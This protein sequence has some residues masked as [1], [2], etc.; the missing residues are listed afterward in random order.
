MGVSSSS[1]SDSELSELLD[2]VDE[3]TSSGKMRRRALRLY[4]QSVI[5]VVINFFQTLTICIADLSIPSAALPVFAVSEVTK[6]SSEGIGL[7]CF[8]AFKSFYSRYVV[9]MLLPVIIMLAILALFSVKFFIRYPGKAAKQHKER[10]PEVSGSGSSYVDE[11]QEVVSYGSSYEEYETAARSLSLIVGSSSAGDTGDVSVERPEM[12]RTPRSKWVIYGGQV[13]YVVFLALNYF[14]FPITSFVLDVF[15]C[16]EDP[17]SGVSYMVSQPSLACDYLSLW[18][19]L[20]PLAAYVFLPILVLF[21]VMVWLEMYGTNFLINT[22]FGFWLDPYRSSRRYFSILFLMRRFLLAVIVTFLDVESLERHV[23]I[24]G[25]LV[26]S[27]VLDYEVKPF[28]YR[29]TTTVDV[30]AHV[31]LIF[32][33]ATSLLADLL[34]VTDES[35]SFA[36]TVLIVCMILGGLVLIW[37]V[38]IP[39]YTVLVKGHWHDQGARDKYLERVRAA[40]AAWVEGESHPYELK[41]R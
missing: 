41:H 19:K 18:E 38:V 32:V 8:S 24:F 12:L 40:H 26:V 5:Q 30:L 1:L 13:V 36:A 6:T 20:V 39:M 17:V 14:F 7:E 15:N 10:R 33:F 3:G 22:S 4:V 35:A 27:V 29:K 31:M 25:V 28:F 16:E 9:M 23:F 21:G 11:E 37:A 2:V 34:N